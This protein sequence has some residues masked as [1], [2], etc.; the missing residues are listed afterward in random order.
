MLLRDTF[1]SH[2]SLKDLNLI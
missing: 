1:I 2:F